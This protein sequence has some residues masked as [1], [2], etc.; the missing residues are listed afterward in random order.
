MSDEFTAQKASNAETVSIW[1]R[2]HEIRDRMVGN[3]CSRFEDTGWKYYDNYALSDD[4]HIFKEQAD[5]NLGVYGIYVC[6][7]IIPMNGIEELHTLYESS[8]VINAKKEIMF[9]FHP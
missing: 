3:P 6:T 4:C 5:R 1:W 7:A 2:H 9:I 8:P